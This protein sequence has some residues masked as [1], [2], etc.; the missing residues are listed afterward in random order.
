MKFFTFIFA[1]VSILITLT[2]GYF[3]WKDNKAMVFNCVIAGVFF[4][5]GALILQQIQKNEDDKELKRVNKLLIDKT[6]EAAGYATGG[7]ENKPFIHFAFIPMKDGSF[8]SVFQVKNFWKYPLS[9]VYYEFTDEYTVAYN[10]RLQNPLKSLKEASAE[11]LVQQAN[12]IREN[13]KIV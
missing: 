3:E 2:T 9:N 12:F 7:L 11:Y 13:P 10:F 6:E 5:I 8:E 4:G 1:A